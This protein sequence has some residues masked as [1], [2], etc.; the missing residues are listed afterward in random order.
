MAKKHWF[1]IGRWTL[2][3]L[4]VVGVVGI[5]YPGHLRQ[6]TA[7]LTDWGR[8]EAERAK[9]ADHQHFIDGEVAAAHRRLETKT[10]IAR[11]L[12]Q[13][14]TTLHSA[15]ANGL[16]AYRTSPDSLV[17][18]RDRYRADS[19]SEAMGMALL[20][21]IFEIDSPGPERE[22]ALRN[23]FEREFQKPYREPDPA[24][25]SSNPRDARH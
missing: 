13:K 3:A 5:T 11:D 16:E 4:A 12:E 17:N 8:N 19:D 20:T 7:D 22:K 21:C 14:R 6:L 25:R 10:A 2:A 15:I 18:L 24:P 23:E 9:S 1:R